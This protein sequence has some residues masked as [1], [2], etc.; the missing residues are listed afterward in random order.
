MVWNC[1]TIVLVSS[2]DS[3]GHAIACSVSSQDKFLQKPSKHEN[4]RL[5]FISL[6]FID[7]HNNFTDQD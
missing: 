5:F 6:Q 7:F 2:L 1:F 3:V 4:C